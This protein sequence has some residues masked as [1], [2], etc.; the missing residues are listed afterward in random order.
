MIRWKTGVGVLLTALMLFPVYWMVNVSL[1]PTDRMR[2]DP[3]DLVPLNPT[4]DGYRRVFAEQLPYLGTSLAI[5]LAT[6]ALTLTIAAPAAFALAK[7]RPRG[8]KTLNFALLIAQMI[9]GIIMALGFYGAYVS[10]GIVNQ[11]WGLVIADST[12]A[13]PFAVLILTAFMS[14]IPDELLQAARIDG[15]GALRA[16]RS[17]VLPISRNGLVTAALFTFLWSW[18]D[19]IFASTLDGGGTLRPIT[20]GIYKYIGN[21]NQEWNAIMATA[22]VASVPAAVLL[23]IA[24]RFVAAGVTAGAVKD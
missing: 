14:G 15:A 6:V 5:G 9:P 17:I 16:F 23:I 13:V 21:N 8:A 19:F 22:V 20:L 11:A 7:L 3:P 4:F 1:T 24:Q 12:I 2:K 18:S 10:F